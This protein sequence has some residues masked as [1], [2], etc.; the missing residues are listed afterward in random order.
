MALVDADTL[1]VPA[2]PDAAVQTDCA[3]EEGHDLELPASHL[4]VTE[5][6]SDAVLCTAVTIQLLQ[7]VGQKQ[8]PR[9]IVLIVE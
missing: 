3:E 7:I 8:V 9:H 5:G 6:D 4:R 2:A 1:T